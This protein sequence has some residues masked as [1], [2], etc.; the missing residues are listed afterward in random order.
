MRLPSVLVCNLRSA[1]PVAVSLLLFRCGLRPTLFSV[2][3]PRYFQTKWV[4]SICG[5]VP[6]A[7]GRA[8]RSPGSN[9]GSPG[10]V[11]EAGV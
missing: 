5:A 1:R 11:T 2:W 4:T 9:A 10:I 6:S 7:C 3:R 8:M